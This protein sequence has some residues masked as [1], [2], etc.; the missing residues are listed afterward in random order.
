MFSIKIKSNVTGNYMTEEEIKKFEV[1]L[2]AQANTPREAYEIVY[3]LKKAREALRFYA[4]ADY[5]WIS[6]VETPVEEDCG[7]RARKAL[8]E[9]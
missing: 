4:D 6:G 3:S 9:E 2:D 5:I 8:G 7:E 1:W